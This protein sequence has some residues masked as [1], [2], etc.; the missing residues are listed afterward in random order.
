M[1]NGTLTIILC[2]ALDYKLLVPSSTISTK[3]VSSKM[4]DFMGQQFQSS[5]VK[6]TLR[7]SLWSKVFS[8]LVIFTKAYLLGLTESSLQVLRRKKKRKKIKKKKYKPLPSKK[9]IIN[10]ISA[11]ILTKGLAISRDGIPSACSCVISR[12]INLTILVQLGT[13][14]F[15]RINI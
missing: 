8:T 11:S 4:V 9:I 14:N 7:S 1:E 6:M 13:T 15:G 10:L 12:K 2:Q 5:I 3:L